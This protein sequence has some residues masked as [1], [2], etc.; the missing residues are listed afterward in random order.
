[1]WQLIKAGMGDLLPAA[2]RA[3]MPAVKRDGSLR[4]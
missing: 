4:E 2:D 1:M 3:N